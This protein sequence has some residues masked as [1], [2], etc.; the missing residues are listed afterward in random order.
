MTVQTATH[1]SVT[2]V[3]ILEVVGS[4]DEARQLIQTASRAWN[5]MASADWLRCTFYEDPE[6]KELAAVITFSD[7]SELLADTRM[8]SSWQE[9]E[10]FASLIRIEYMRIHGRVSAEVRSWLDRFQGPC[11]L[12]DAHLAGF[13]R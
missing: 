13:T 2:L 8:I 6:A 12:F 7:S 10:R 1:E 3:D 9:F 11:R 5:A 4:F